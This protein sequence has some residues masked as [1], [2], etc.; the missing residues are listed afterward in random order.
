MADLTKEA[1]ALLLEIGRRE[2][3]WTI[4]KS[5][6]RD[7]LKRAGLIFSRR[8]NG[9]AYVWGLTYQGAATFNVMHGREP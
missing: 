7:E 9:S 8:Y 5:A 6:A 2:A 4:P 3:D 1:K